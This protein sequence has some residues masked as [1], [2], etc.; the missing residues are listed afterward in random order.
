M[1][2]YPSHHLSRSLLPCRADVAVAS[3][4]LLCIGLLGSIQNIVAAGIVR[5]PAALG[6]HV[7][8]AKTFRAASVAQVLKQVETDYP[9]V[10][11]SL[12]DVFFPS[13]LRVK[14]LEDVEFWRAALNKRMA[15]N[16]HGTRLDCLP[17]VVVELGK[18]GGLDIASTARQG[19]EEN[20]K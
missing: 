16:H 4:D 9:L 3:S 2:L 7:N 8:H 11:T 14:E 5:K 6:I 10:G 12:L 1:I 20:E 19:R 15:P 18:G 17:P 13:S